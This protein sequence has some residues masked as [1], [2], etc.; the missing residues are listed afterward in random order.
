MHVM[1]PNSGIISG[2]EHLVRLS[3]WPSNILDGDQNKNPDENLEV[4]RGLTNVEPVSYA[5]KAASKTNN[6]KNTVWKLI[7]STF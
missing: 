7:M 2:C 4:D 6:N 5:T 1:I 3:V